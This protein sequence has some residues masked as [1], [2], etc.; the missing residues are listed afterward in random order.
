M[1]HL[2]MRKD[3][4]EQVKLL[5]DAIAALAH[6]DDPPEYAKQLLAKFADAEYSAID[7]LAALIESRRKA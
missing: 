5:F 6:W 4:L 1:A 3:A 2:G 7:Q